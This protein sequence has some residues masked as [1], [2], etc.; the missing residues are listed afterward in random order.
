MPIVRID[1]QSGTSTEHKRALLQGVRT[2]ITSALGVDDSRVAQRIIESSPE[3]IDAP[4]RRVDQLTIIDI[5]M[6][7]GRDAQ[8]K[9][10]LYEEIMARL[11][12]EPG[13]SAEN[14]TIVVHDPPAE[15]FCLGGNT[16][17]G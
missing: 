8:R 3:D 11:A 2:A 14:I 6:L 10:L 7:S 5:T 4:G 9:R 17:A 16:P 13:I 15:C 12:N 1:I